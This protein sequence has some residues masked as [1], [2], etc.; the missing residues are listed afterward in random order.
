MFLFFPVCPDITC[1]LLSWIVLNPEL[2]QTVIFLAESVVAF[3]FGTIT[4]QKYGLMKTSILSFINVII[5]TLNPCSH[6][7]IVQNFRQFSLTTWMFKKCNLAERF[8]ESCS[9]KSL[10][11]IKQN[12]LITKIFWLFLVSNFRTLLRVVRFLVDNFPASDFVCLHFETLSSIF[13]KR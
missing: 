7:N 1:V 3:E 6:A 13:I 5:I 8:H 9:Q 10:W 12:S 4:Q 2:P 11:Q